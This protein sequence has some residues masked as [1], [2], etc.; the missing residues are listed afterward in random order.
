MAILVEGGDF[1]SGTKAMARHSQL[2]LTQESMG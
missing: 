2:W 1:R